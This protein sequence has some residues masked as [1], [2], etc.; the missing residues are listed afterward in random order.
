M[1]W[2]LSSDMP[3]LRTAVDSAP[4]IFNQR[5]WEL[6]LA[7]NDRVELYSVPDETLGEKL[8]REVVISCGA[9]LYN[10]RLAIKVAGRTPTSWLLPA[11]TRSQGYSR[12][13]RGSARCSHRS[14]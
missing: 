8:P 12:R 9:A 4:S 6:R 3:R 1:S 13:W 10:L 11:W 14:R 2:D 7:A 5:P